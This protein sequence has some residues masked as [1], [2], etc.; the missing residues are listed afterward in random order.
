MGAL[1]AY[2]QLNHSEVLGRF[3]APAYD[4][5]KKDCS[6]KVPAVNGSTQTEDDFI[7]CF[8]YDI[9]LMTYQNISNVTFFPGFPRGILRTLARRSQEEQSVQR[10]KSHASS[11][12]ARSHSV[13]NRL[14]RGF[15]CST[16]WKVYVATPKTQ[17]FF[18]ED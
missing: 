15:G 13:R 7:R 1:A 9:S 5:I 18:F 8:T 11:P 2:V 14:W 16:G 4:L 12:S 6:P 17:R 3:I 10:V